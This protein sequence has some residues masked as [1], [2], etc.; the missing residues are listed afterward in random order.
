[1]ND[2]G[3]LLYLLALQLLVVATCSIQLPCLQ[4]I[5]LLVQTAN[6]GCAILLH[7]AMV[8]VALLF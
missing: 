1:M 8:G 4:S 2:T 7:P 3:R 5:A 6:I